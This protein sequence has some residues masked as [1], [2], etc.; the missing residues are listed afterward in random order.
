MTA[1]G[2]SGLVRMWIDGWVVSR[3]AS[4][5]AVEPWGWTIDVGL[6][7]HV[8]RHV[9]PEPTAAQV[10][11]L[12]AVTSAPGTWL[13]LF[14]DDDTVRP[15]VTPDW[16]LDAPAFLMSCPLGAERVRLPAGYV[17][18][19]WT[20]GDVVRV[21]IRT[22]DGQLAARGQL[23]V[24]GRVGVPDQIETAPAHR[25]RGL[26]AVVMRTLQHAAHQAGAETGVLVA[27]SAG[28]ALYTT[29]GWTTRAP[30]ASLCFAPP[31]AAG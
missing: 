24:A 3:G 2:V 26:G 8:A 22:T 25:R 16:R 5:P 23:A 4:D 9:L 14:A 7:G 20:R 6:T 30:M 27:S 29:L 18:T 28:R 10:G 15:W 31:A 12:V 17:R 19:S 21:L 11:E 13:K 1:V